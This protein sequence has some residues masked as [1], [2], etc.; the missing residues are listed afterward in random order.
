[1]LSQDQH[2]ARHEHHGGGK[3]QRRQQVG[4]LPRQVG[5]DVAEYRHRRLAGVADQYPQQREHH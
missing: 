2:A 1:L 5:A 3:A 4:A